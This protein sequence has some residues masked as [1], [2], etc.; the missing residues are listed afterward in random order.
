MNDFCERKI[1]QATYE[2]ARVYGDKRTIP[3]VIR[4]IIVEKSKTDMV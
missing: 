4:E 1:G 3:D 2:I